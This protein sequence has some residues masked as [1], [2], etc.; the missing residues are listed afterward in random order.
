MW[1]GLLRADV[2]VRYCSDNVT[3]LGGPNT[4]LQVD[5]T[6][7]VRRKFNV[8]RVVRK[9]WLVDGIQYGTKMVF[10]EI[11]DRRDVTLESITQQHAALGGRIR[12][13]MWSGYNNLS[14]LGYI[15]ETLQA[16]AQ[17]LAARYDVD[18]LIIRILSVAAPGYSLVNSV[19]EGELMNLCTIARQVF[20]SQASLIDVQPPIKWIKEV[21]SEYALHARYSV[22]VIV[23]EPI[24]PSIPSC[25]DAF[26][27]LPF[28]GLIDG[29]IL[30]MHGGL[31]PKGWASNSRGVSYVFGKDVVFEMNSTLNIELVARAHQ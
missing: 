26:A 16:Q 9:D 11:V 19:K 23:S 2:L 17:G 27:A 1:P 4:I 15:H 20:L 31:S 12:T 3:Q 22:H 6:N 14:N 30:C 10:V 25:R 18:D 21:S 7:I 28:T 5:E 29:K 13:D 24:K 8:G